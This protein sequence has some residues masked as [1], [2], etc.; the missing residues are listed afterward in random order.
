MKLALD[1]KTKLRLIGVAVIVSIVAIF[2][3]AMMK[4]SASGHRFEDTMSVSVSLPEKPALPKVSEASESQVFETVK[5]AKVDVQAPKDAPAAYELAAAEP[6]SSDVYAE[7]D[8]RPSI[9]AAAAA[10]AIAPAPKLAPSK[11]KAVA[12]VSL[13]KKPQIQAAKPV[14]ATGKTITSARKPVY[15]VQLALFSKQE[16]AT[17]LVTQLRAKGYT[18]RIN[19]LKT[20]A[21]P[22]YKVIVG[23][24]NERQAAQKLQVQ[25]AGAVR[26]NGFIVNTGVA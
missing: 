4:A 17:R 18:A 22:R 15:G 21:G 14:T 9:Q 3:P 2:L 24:V 19:T 10:S 26:I 25:L 5:V 20:A 6:I 23:A 12:R 7:S 16:L 13:P 8:A 11:P 1:E